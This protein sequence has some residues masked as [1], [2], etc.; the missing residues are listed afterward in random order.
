VDNTDRIIDVVFSFIFAVPLILSAVL[1]IR[2]MVVSRFF[3]NV[4][5]PFDSKRVNRYLLLSVTSLLIIIA[6]FLGCCI[7]IKG[8][9]PT[10]KFPLAIE[11]SIVVLMAL[12]IFGGFGFIYGIGQLGHSGVSPGGVLRKLSRS[13][14]EETFADEEEAVTPNNTQ[15]S[16]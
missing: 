15:D 6:L 16:G 7:L 5:L 3:K 12:F 2:R 4:D 1:L 9:F 8:I 11:L 13:I 10:Y 14:S